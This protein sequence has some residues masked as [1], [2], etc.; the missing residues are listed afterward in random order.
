[1]EGRVVLCVCWGGGG[2][3]IKFIHTTLICVKH[4]TVERMTQN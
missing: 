4:L 1:M 3:Y 2:G